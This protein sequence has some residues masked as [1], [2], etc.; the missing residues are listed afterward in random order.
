MPVQCGVGTRYRTSATRLFC[1]ER[2]L[3]TRTNARSDMPAPNE[4]EVRAEDVFVRNSRIVER[5]PDVVMKK[6]VLETKNWVANRELENA[7]FV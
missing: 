3:T 6:S 7:H 2:R 5:E 4:T 1:S